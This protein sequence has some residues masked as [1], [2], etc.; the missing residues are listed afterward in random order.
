MKACQPATL[1]AGRGISPSFLKGL[2]H[3]TSGITTELQLTVYIMLSLHTHTHTHTHTLCFSFYLDQG[4]CQHLLTLWV[5]LLSFGNPHFPH[6]TPVG[7]VHLSQAPV[8]QAGLVRA[9]PL[10]HLAPL[11]LQNRLRCRHVAK[12]AKESHFLGYLE[13]RLCEPGG[14]QP[15]VIHGHL[16]TT[17]GS[18]TSSEAEQRY[19]DTE[20]LSSCFRIVLEIFLLWCNLHMG[21]R[22][23]LNCAAQCNFA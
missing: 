17:Q 16:A 8:T 3:T 5:N 15:G 12:C 21:T 6:L 23:N 18:P 11:Q 4:V 13:K 22:T 7:L 19:G 2:H 10:L 1:P 20:F 14:G 9:S